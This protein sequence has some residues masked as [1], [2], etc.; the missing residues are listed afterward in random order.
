MV[1][2]KKGRLIVKTMRRPEKPTAA[3]LA[4]WDEFDKS[5]FKERDRDFMRLE[6]K[7]YENLTTLQ[8]VLWGQCDEA[9]QSKV[10]AHP[11][12]DEDVSDI[13]ELMNILETLCENEGELISEMRTQTWNACKQVYAFEQPDDMSLNDYHNEF[14]L[15][16]KVAK[17]SGGQ[18]YTIQQLVETFRES[19]Y[20]ATGD[21]MDEFDMLPDATKKLITDRA[22]ERQL[23]VG[24][25]LNSSDKQFGE[26]KRDRVN[27]ISKGGYEYPITIDDARM[28]MEKFKPPRGHQIGAKKSG[29]TGARNMPG[30]RKT[31]HALVSNGGEQEGKGFQCWNCDRWNECKKYNCP[32]TTKEDGSPTR[33][34]SRQHE[35]G[36]QQL[37]F[38]LEPWEDSIEDN[39]EPWEDSVDDN[40]YTIG[41]GLNINGMTRSRKEVVVEDLQGKNDHIFNRNN[42]GCLNKEWIL[43]DNCS[44]VHV[45]YNPC[46][47][48]NIRTAKKTLHLYTNAGKVILTKEGDVPG[49]GPV[50]Y[51]PNGIA[52][53]LSFNG[54]SKTAGYKVEYQS[55]VE[56]AFK[57]TNPRGQ[58]RKFIPCKKGLYHWKAT[59]RKTVQFAESG[60]SLAITT[61]EGNK[62]K[63][64]NEDVRK[65]EKARHLQH[66]AGFLGEEQLMYVTRRNQL[67]NSPITPRCVALKNRIF[68][69]SI[70]G[71]QG[72]TVRNK[73]DAVEIEALVPLT[74]EKRYHKITLFVESR[75]SPM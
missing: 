22:A 44:T 71:L 14:K 24:F 65:A 36:N 74:I 1:S 54:V 63:Y 52:N 50:W 9:V 23:A 17:R 70:P 75:S 73:K 64:S 25:I 42:K 38:G 62:Q 39:V 6:N 40:P 56:D 34:E 11:D 69:P 16:A 19:E 37:N 8:S 53:V 57:V 51:H 29:M 55:W 2:L 18:L 48:Q 15:R 67:M 26:F 27:S 13:F 10:K 20:Y 31:G 47:L 45:F 61:I 58:I 3:E 32:H 5:Q 43:L 35:E 7:T 59:S 12:Y 28:E 66:A 49:L 72:R 68:G 41:I 46:F 60:T 21:G 30:Q 33:K 4:E